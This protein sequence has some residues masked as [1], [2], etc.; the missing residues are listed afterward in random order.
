MAAAVAIVLGALALL[1]VFWG[2][3]GVT[4][5]SVAIPE[6]SGKPAFEASG[7][8]TFAVAAALAL[9]GLLILARGGLL[10]SPL[11]PFF[12]DAGAFLVAAA[13]LLRAIGDFRLVGFFKRVRDT[14]FAAWD[15]RLFTPLSL[16][17]G[18][19]SLWVA[20]S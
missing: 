5:R 18:L 17:I 16:G 20:L 4:A 7:P 12:I 2:V 9:A 13:F 8:A 19:G 10:S 1:H 11:P 3:G 15:T 14:P 6:V